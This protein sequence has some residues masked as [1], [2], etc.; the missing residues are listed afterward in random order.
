MPIDR[1]LAAAEVLML[2]VACLRLVTLFSGLSYDVAAMC[3][4]TY[5]AKCCECADG[6][7]R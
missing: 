4:S 7:Q 1:I 3:Y 6:F 5:Q 2:G